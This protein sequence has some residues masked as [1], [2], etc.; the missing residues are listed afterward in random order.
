MYDP[1]KPD[2]PH[3]GGAQPTW[4]DLSIACEL[5]YAYWQ[6]SDKE[7]STVDER[8]LQHTTQN[9]L[10]QVRN[11][12]TKIDMMD[13]N[14]RILPNGIW[15]AENFDDPDQTT[16]TDTDLVPIG[17]KQKLSST[18]QVIFKTILFEKDWTPML[19]TIN[20]LATEE[21]S[22]KETD[23]RAQGFQSRVNHLEKYQ[24]VNKLNAWKKKAQAHY[25]WV[26]ELDLAATHNDYLQL[27]DEGEDLHNQLTRYY[28]DDWPS[29]E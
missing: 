10:G 5:I 6:N 2:T 8:L 24:P 17:T 25:Q 13:D 27:T 22:V 28:H 9:T 7:P 19:A 16:I 21:V 15:L 4:G 29:T 14:H 11:F 20:Q 3:L 1:S 23:E 12:L 26:E 18:E